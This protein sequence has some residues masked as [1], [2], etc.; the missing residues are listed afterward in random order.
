MQYNNTHIEKNKPS[1]I[2]YKKFYEN[3]QN[4]VEMLVTTEMRAHAYADAKAHDLS[5]QI[6]RLLSGYDQALQEIS[7][8]KEK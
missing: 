3:I 6:F 4:H 2:D 7:E 1:E 8:L 5:F